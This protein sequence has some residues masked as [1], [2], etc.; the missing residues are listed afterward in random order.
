MIYEVIS[1]S[2]QLTFLPPRSN[3][4]VFDGC[5]LYLQKLKIVKL[6]KLTNSFN[7]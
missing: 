6:R 1:P 3:F 7:F 2:M 5:Y 4:A